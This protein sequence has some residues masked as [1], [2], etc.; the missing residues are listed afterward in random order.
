MKLLVI[1]A[2]PNEGRKALV[3]AGGTAAGELYIERL[4]FL[5]PEAE[6]DLFLPADP[7]SALPDGA[8]LEQY[9]GVIWSGSSLTIYDEDPRVKDQIDLARSIL[10]HGVPS[11]GSCWAA[12]LAATAAGGSCR[13]NPRGREFGVSETISLT[14]SGRDHPMY[15]GKESTFRALV[16]HVDEVETL[17]P[18][19][20]LLASNAWSEVQ[21]LTVD[22]QGGTFW[23]LQYHPEY[24]LEEIVALTRLRDGELIEQGFFDDEAEAERYRRTLG[25][26]Q[27]GDQEADPAE[28]PPEILDPEQRLCEVRNW[29]DLCVKPRSG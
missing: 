21:S 19:A 12:Q 13:R 17:P 16:C 23:A 8:A 15:R 3:A 20:R 14:E 10:R 18:G 5:E 26:I 4:L 6:I 29:L 25:A 28:I 1:D 9:D 7:A 11:F 27:A 2:Y 22:Y 24:D